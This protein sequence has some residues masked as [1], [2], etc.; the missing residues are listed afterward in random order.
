M[1]IPVKIDPDLADLIP[2]YLDNRRADTEKMRAA[3]AAK[4]FDVVRVTGHNLKGTGAAYGFEPISTHGAALEQAGV[5]GLDGDVTAATAAA[6]AE[7]D[8]LE[9]YLREVEI[10]H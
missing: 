7:L 9:Q 5:A 6:N 2:G 4:D 8:A 1:S 3:V 10:I